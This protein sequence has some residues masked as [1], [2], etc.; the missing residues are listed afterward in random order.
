M[1]SMEPDPQ[2]TL[3]NMPS[4]APE[5]REFAPLSNLRIRQD[6]AVL[7][8]MVGLIIF[9]MVFALGVERGKRLARGERLLL[10]SPQA[11]TP[12][13]TEGTNSYDALKT[14][15]V[16]SPTDGKTRAPRHDVKQKQRE[17]GKESAPGMRKE[18]RTVAGNAL[19]PGDY[20]I[21]VVT[22]RKADLAQEE[23]QRLQGR[24]EEAFL[25]EKQGWVVLLV[26]PFATKARATSR[27]SGLK[28]KYEDCFIR[29]L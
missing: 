14:A 17:R 16:S 28:R 4:Q 11:A 9:A 21:Q 7:L 1:T 24:G 10:R 8:A 2:L 18:P 27:L 3:F 12:G 26:G 20:A 15:P 23:L 6:H 25:L 5:R 19:Q 29:R 13:P 22:Y